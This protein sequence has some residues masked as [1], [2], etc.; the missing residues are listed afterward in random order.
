MAGTVSYS[1]LTMDSYHLVGVEPDFVDAIGG[2]DLSPEI[3]NLFWLSNHA[4][5]Q[6]VPGSGKAWGKHYTPVLG[7]LAAVVRDVEE[8]VILY[9]KLGMPPRSFYD[10]FRTED[11][12]IY[13][14]YDIYGGDVW[15]DSV[16]SGALDAAVRDE[17][18]SAHAPACG[19]VIYARFGRRA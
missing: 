4:L 9:K 12:S 10:W 13:D 11:V 18:R 8:D 7:G 15:R 14:A 2:H 6:N 19:N 3:W 17:A 16:V 5:L 1:P